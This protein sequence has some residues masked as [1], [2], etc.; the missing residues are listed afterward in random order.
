MQQ[1][2]NKLTDTDK[3]IVL[4]TCFHIVLLIIFLLVRSGLDLGSEF[5]EI[6]FMSPASAASKSRMSTETPPAAKAASSAGSKGAVEKIKETATTKAK[7]KDESAHKTV[8]PPVSLPKRTMKEEE[9]P[10]LPVQRDKVNITPERETNGMPTADSDQTKKDDQGKSPE[11]SSTGAENAQ[12][13]N[14]DQANE[15]EDGTATNS[16]GSNSNLPYTIEGD[17]AK[18]RI[19]S[20]V[21]PT[22]PPGLQREAVV[23]IRFW[24]LPDGRIG[25]M[26]PMQKG[27]PE[28]EALTMKTMRQ[29]RFSPLSPLEEQKSVQ[30]LITFVYKLR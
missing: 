18:R 24:V 7:P 17:A 16:A 29:W 10:Q 21:L 15:K 1:L 9:P 14:S 23:K 2:F 3:S 13:N 19:L 5:A 30:G 22:Y 25:Q 11:V 27:D 12:N 26:L 8:T 6:G 28:L 20:Q 4:S